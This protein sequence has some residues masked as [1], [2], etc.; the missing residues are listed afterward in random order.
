MLE[1]L[2][3]SLSVRWILFSQ[4][5]NKKLE[6]YSVLIIDNVGMLS[7]LYRYGEF[8]YVGG[9]FGKGL[10][11]IL[12]AACQGI[13]VLFGNKNYQKFQEAVDLINRGGAFEIADYPDLKLKYELLNVPQTFLLA[14]EV[15]RQYVEHNVGATEKI[16]QYCR[17]VLK[18]ES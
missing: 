17:T 16:M 10:H 6:D 3:R 9:A 13:P 11:N 15:C 18:P 4:A 8:A 2:E 5:A 14:C 7:Q 12:E 1:N